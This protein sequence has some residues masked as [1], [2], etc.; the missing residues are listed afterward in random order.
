MIIQKTAV[1]VV[2]KR[3]DG[4]KK[5]YYNNEN[6]LKE[7]FNEATVLPVPDDAPVE[8]PRIIL[9]TLHEHSQLSIALNAATF[10]VKFDSGFEKN[11]S[12]CAKYIDERMEKVFE[13]LNLLTNN[14]YEYIGVV[15]SII[16]D[17]IEQ[18]GAKKIVST[19][20][21]ANKIRDIYDVNLKL[22]FIEDNEFFTNIMLQNARRFKPG[23]RIDEA[24]SLNDTNQIA[25]SIGAVIDI[26]DRYGFNYKPN[27][28]SDSSVMRKLLESM[29]NVI[30]NKLSILIEKGEY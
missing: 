10:E 17:E 16:Y 26:N 11:W 20:V 5:I 23:V 15:S 8:I 21:N 7:Y 27:Y 24:G 4:I 2:Y 1:S 29:G 9:K 30:N 18:E 12:N 19:L 14:C 13:F 22:T 3:I 28:H 25:E 6:I